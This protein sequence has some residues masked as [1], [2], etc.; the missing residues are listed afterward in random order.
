[1]ETMKNGMRRCLV[2]NGHG[3]VYEFPEL[4][5]EI[6]TILSS[7][8]I[9][10]FVEGEIEITATI[11][12]YTP[13]RVVTLKDLLEDR[14]SGM[15]NS[16]RRNDLMFTSDPRLSG[17]HATK[18]PQNGNKEIVV[19]IMLHRYYCDVDAWVNPDDMRVV[20]REFAKQLTRPLYIY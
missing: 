16:L 18:L 15:V 9:T 8:G 1:M 17:T 6:S 12:L 4:K 20:L 13:I 5:D 10:T 2:Q 3:I 19:A 7:A 14:V 11:Q